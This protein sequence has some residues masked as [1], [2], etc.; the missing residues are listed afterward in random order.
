MLW[1]KFEFKSVMYA[2]LIKDKLHKVFSELTKD[3]RNH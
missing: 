2:I 1:G 3:L